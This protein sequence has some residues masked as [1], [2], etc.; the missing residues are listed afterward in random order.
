MG[1]SGGHIERLLG[2]EIGYGYIEIII[3][4]RRE[5]W[6][7]GKALMCFVLFIRVSEEALKVKYTKLKN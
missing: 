6:W 5:M 7:V 4:S 1:V 3:C 2:D